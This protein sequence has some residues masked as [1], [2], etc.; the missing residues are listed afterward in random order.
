MISPNTHACSNNRTRVHLIHI[1]MIFNSS[2]DIQ[3]NFDT[4]ISNTDSSNTVDIYVEV[5]CKPQPLVFFLIFYLRILRS[6]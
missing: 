3:L 1:S 6:F 2:K 4:C 5:I